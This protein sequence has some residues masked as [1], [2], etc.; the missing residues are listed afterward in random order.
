VLLGWTD[1]IVAQARQR[2]VW[3]YFNNDIHGH[4]IDDALTLR[5][6]VAQAMR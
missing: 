4:A 5:S 3:C 2:P 6:M 1:W